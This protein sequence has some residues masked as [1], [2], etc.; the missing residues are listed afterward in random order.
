MDRRIVRNDCQ[1]VDDDD[2]LDFRHKRV[3][4]ARLFLDIESTLERRRRLGWS[5]R[6][7]YYRETYVQG[8]A[9][10]RAYVLDSN[11]I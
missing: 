2:W 10:N 6:Y 3:S 8:D 5:H 1:T 11:G 7:N 4:S 9:K